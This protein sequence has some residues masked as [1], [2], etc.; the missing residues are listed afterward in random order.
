VITTTKLCC[1]YA[2]NPLAVGAAAPRLSW[3]LNSPGRGGKQSAYQILAASTQEGLRVGEADL[4]DSGRVESAEQA[5]EY[6]GRAIGAGERCWWSVKA[7][8]EDGAEGTFAPAGWFETGLRPGD[9]SAEWIGFPAAWPGRSLLF[10]RAF[11]LKKSVKRARV[12]MAGLG[13]SELWINGL[14]VNNRVL[15]PPQSDLSRTV[16]FTTDAVEDFLQPGEN[17]IGVCAGNGWYGTV[18]LLLQLDIVYQDGEHERI[19]S[20]SSFFAPWMVGPGAVLEN[21]VYGGEVYD[22]RL[23]VKDWCRPSAV[24]LGG[25]WVLVLGSDG[26]GGKLEPAMLEPIRVVETLKPISIREPKS[27]ITVFDLGQNIA[28]WARLR[29]SGVAGTK[30]T[31]RFAES[32]YPDGTI[33]QENLRSARARD[34]YILKGGGEEIW[35]PSFTYHGFRYIQVEGWPGKLSE[36]AV[37]GRVVRSDVPVS[38]EFA[39]SYDLLN[40]IHRMVRRTEMSNMHSVPTD[41]PQRDE[42]MGWLNDMAA[43]SEELV[44]NFGAGRLLAKWLQDIA[45]TQDAEGTITDTAPYRW[46]RRPADPVSVCYLLIPW[47]LYTHYGDRRTLSL[48]Y[49]GMKKWVDFLNRSAE[50]GILDYSYYGDWSPPVGLGVTGSLGDS[51]VS[52]D[53]PGAL[54]STA[55]LAYSARLLAQIAQV[56]GKPGDTQRYLGLYERVST[57][58]NL[59][60]WDEL[61]SG[62][63]ANNQSANAIALYMGL[64][65]PERIDATANSLVHAVT[66]HNKHL[67][68]GNI[69]TKYLLE[70]LTQSGRSDVALAITLQE[71]YPSWGNMLANGATTLWER[72]EQATGGGMNSH[73][74]PMMGSVGAWFYRVLAGVRV[75]PAAPGFAQFS[76]RP[77]VLEGID[78][79]KASMDT[80]RGKI[81]VDW[82]RK[83]NELNLRV[84]IPA[85]CTAR[86]GVPVEGWSP[87]YEG[88]TLVWQDEQP[89]DLPEGIEG[90]WRE[91]DRVVLT[92][93]SGEYR[94]KANV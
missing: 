76:V 15:D 5:V 82:E 13:W 38:G 88:E 18:R 64:V 24:P 75:H 74:H 37:V 65:P 33:N 59:R 92:I 10:R 16:L 25:E 77:D 27:G 2:E 52:R 9:W 8:D 43:R 55:C 4:W 89:L 93:G 56:L 31:L 47:L 34:E 69:C 21:S 67:S 61:A 57:A 78:W 72:W 36:D 42:R 40:R 48:R 29:A 44:Y 35:E 87:V 19:K 26:P 81:S 73:N 3:Q 60:Y 79:V 91:G 11:Q 17:V 58:F 68:T 85:G 54:V 14:R 45:D 62:Y 90:I 66:A 7:W 1:E 83:G 23:E 30:I 32:L 22:A 41:C 94:F 51:A 50:D 71:D 39:C 46:G 86:V 63:G 53:T 20:D 80:V 12:S 6:A 84:A 28:G 49:S 70:A